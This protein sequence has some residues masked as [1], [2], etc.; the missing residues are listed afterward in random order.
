M[1]TLLSVK[2]PHVVCIK[3]SSYAAITVTLKHL[4]AWLLTKQS[5]FTLIKVTGKRR[6]LAN[7][8]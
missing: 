3:T 7:F 1:Q 4:A 5:H 8:Q 6:Q 2:S